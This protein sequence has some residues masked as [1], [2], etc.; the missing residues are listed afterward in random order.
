M[1]TK[2]VCVP[3]SSSAHTLMRRGVME[4]PVNHHKES[5]LRKG[6]FLGFHPMNFNAI[7]LSI[8]GRVVLSTNG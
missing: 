5:C 8:R 2:S 7:P 3:H 6:A 1:G 4:G